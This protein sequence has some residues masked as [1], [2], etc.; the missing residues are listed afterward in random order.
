V[1]L[2]SFNAL[3]A[4]DAASELLSVC[5][6]RPWALEVAAARPFADVSSAQQIADDVWLKLGPIAWR[7]AL[8]SHPRIGERGGASPEYSRRE[9]AGLAEVTDDLRSAIAAGNREYE[10]RFGH[11]FL[12]SAAGRGPEEILAN[13]RLRLTNDPDAE[14]RVAAEEHRRITRLRLSKL[15][16]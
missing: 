6:S 7:E 12:I 5:H 15:V 1:N 8:D 10:A 14:L 3:S 9:Q 13:L 2:A 16:S 4:E 11:I